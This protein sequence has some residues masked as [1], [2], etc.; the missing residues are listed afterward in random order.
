MK[1]SKIVG[2]TGTS[3]YTGKI[4]DE[5]C[6]WI[7]EHEGKF[8]VDKGPVLVDTLQEAKEYHDADS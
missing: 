6:K 1:W 2:M 4:G 8:L 7:H 3:Y 5:D